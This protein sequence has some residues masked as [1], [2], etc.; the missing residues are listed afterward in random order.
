MKCKQCEAAGIESTVSVG[1]STRTAMAGRRFYD[2]KGRLH[3]HDNNTT[4]TPYSCS[5]GHQWKERKKNRC[6]CEKEEAK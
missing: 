2:E 1:V 5:Q 3:D 4:T 6:W